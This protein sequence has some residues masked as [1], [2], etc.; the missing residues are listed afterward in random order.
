V[1]WSVNTGVGSNP[2]ADKSVF[3]FVFGFFRKSMLLYT[4]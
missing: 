1:F 2:T 3:D 4:K